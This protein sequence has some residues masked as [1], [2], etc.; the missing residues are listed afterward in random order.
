MDIQL[1]YVL[2]EIASRKAYIIPLKTKNEKEIYEA[3]NKLINKIK[4][5]KAITSDNGKEFTYKKV[6]S[7]FIKNNI[8]HYFGQAD[9]KRTLKDLIE[10]LKII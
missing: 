3:I 1:C 2:I 6:E 10:Q 9:D 7:L 4:V 8:K 5:I